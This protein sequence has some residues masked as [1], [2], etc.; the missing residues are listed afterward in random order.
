MDTDNSE[1]DSLAG[2]GTGTG[3]V[4][5]DANAVSASPEGGRMDELKEEDSDAEQEDMSLVHD[6]DQAVEDTDDDHAQEHSAWIPGQGVF[7]DY[8]AIMDIMIQHVT[9]PGELGSEAV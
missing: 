8:A 3:T 4:D 1:L 2:T 9:Y 5:G 7:V 6:P